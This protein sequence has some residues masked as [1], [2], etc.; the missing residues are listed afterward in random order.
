MSSQKKPGCSFSPAHK[1]TQK[2]LGGGGRGGG[3]NKR[4]AGLVLFKCVE[5]VQLF[6]F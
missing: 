2:K 6:E 3:G 5:V 4:D 1:Y